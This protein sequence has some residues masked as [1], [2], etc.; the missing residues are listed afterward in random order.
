M[1]ISEK[2]RIAQDYPAV[3]DILKHIPSD[4]WSACRIQK[5]RRDESLFFHGDPVEYIY[6][7]CK[8]II[9]ISSASISGRE[10]KVVFVNEGNIIGEME[11]L[12]GENT[13]VYNAKAYTDCVLIKVS[14]DVFLKWISSDLNLA[15]FMAVALAKKLYD[16]SMETVKYTQQPALIIFA[17]LLYSEDSGIVYK[18]R[19]QLAKTCGVSIRT[20]NRCINKL[21]EEK[22]VSIYKGK[23]KIT[24]EQREK[25]GQ[26]IRR[27]D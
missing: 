18:T 12:V 27:N 25:I 5:V 24:K 23:I 10:I 16:A 26:L 13:L 19:Q 20:I 17:T 15:N 8:G 6:L 1:D 14:V 21:K 22:F 11:A 2:N 3:S 7:V 4:V 9:E